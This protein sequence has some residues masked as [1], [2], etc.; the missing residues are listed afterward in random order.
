MAELGSLNAVFLLSFETELMPCF[1]VKYLFIL[2]LGSTETPQIHLPVF[3]F[4]AFLIYVSALPLPRTLL[5]RILLLPVQFL[6]LILYI[7][8]LK[9]I[10]ANPTL[11]LLCAVQYI[12]K[13][14][15]S[16][17]L[18][19]IESVRTYQCSTA[20][21][22]K[23]YIICRHCSSFA[24]SKKIFACG[25]IKKNQKKLFTYKRKIIIL[26][27]QKPPDLCQIYLKIQKFSKLFDFFDIN[28]E[29]WVLYVQG[30]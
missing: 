9:Q 21:S 6:A 20:S 12:L 17:V 7:F 18:L 22:Q 25:W 29:C 5:F 27:V 16:V 24:M 30:T 26:T 28:V 11:N 23:L 3:L 19:D 4:P 2:I 8:G 13:C 1:P 14:G 15:V 10:K